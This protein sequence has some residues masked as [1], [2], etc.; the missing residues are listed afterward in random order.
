MERNLRE[1]VVDG[2]TL[3]APGPVGSVDLRFQ[4]GVDVLYGRNGSGKTRI[5]RSLLGTLGQS[6]G[7]DGGLVHVHFGKVITQIDDTP[8]VMHHAKSLPWWQKLLIDRIGEAAERVRPLRC[9]WLDPSVDWFSSKIASVAWRRLL[10]GAQ[11]D[12]E[13]AARVV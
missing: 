13:L 8:G 1:L 2:V 4:P 7:D 9:P 11:F 3:Q 5:L 6:T 12:Q 10:H